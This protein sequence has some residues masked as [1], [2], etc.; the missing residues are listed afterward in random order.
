V[1]LATDPGLREL[2]GRYL[3]ARKEARCQLAEDRDAVEAPYG[4]CAGSRANLRRKRDGE[5]VSF[6]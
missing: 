1:W 4:I 3:A 5:R 6:G 2:T